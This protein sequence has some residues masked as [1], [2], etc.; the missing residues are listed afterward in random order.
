MYATLVAVLIWPR[1]PEWSG[2][3]RCRAACV[4]L[5]RTPPRLTDPD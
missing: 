2:S 3:P 5:L 1:V 4:L